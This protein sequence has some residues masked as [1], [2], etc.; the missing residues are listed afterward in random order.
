MGYFVL[1]ANFLSIFQVMLKLRTT[2]QVRRFPTESPPCPQ[3]DGGFLGSNACNAL[4]NSMD[5]SDGQFHALVRRDETL[6]I[7][8]PQICR[9]I[10]LVY[11][12]E[13]KKSS[14]LGPN[15]EQRTSLRPKK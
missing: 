14:R 11:E 5:S 13:R 10:P 8:D 6:W 12:V 2:T 7:F 9:R 3:G 15:L 4:W 1:T